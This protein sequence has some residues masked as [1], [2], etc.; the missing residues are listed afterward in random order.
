MLS[1]AVLSGATPQ[2]KAAQI[3]REQERIER[4][5]TR[6]DMPLP[7]G[8]ALSA[9][10][11][12]SAEIKKIRPEIPNTTL[13]ADAD[14]IEATL[15]QI[16]SQFNKIG[17][18]F[19][20]AVWASQKGWKIAR[21]NSPLRLTPDKPIDSGSFVDYVTSDISAKIVRWQIQNE[22]P[23]IDATVLTKDMQLIDRAQP[24]IVAAYEKLGWTATD[25]RSASL[26]AWKRARLESPLGPSETIDVQSLVESTTEMGIMVFTSE[27][28]HA[29]VFINSVKIGTTNAQ[30]N[31][32]LRF[33]V[34][35]QKVTVRFIKADFQPQNLDCVAKGQDTV[36]CKAELKHQP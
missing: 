29:D 8:I 24:N 10:S 31:E 12:T 5:P 3:K 25:A 35:G 1:L 4:V 26:V 19:D 23:E 27:P 30:K 34:D 17:L 36:I 2:K 32:P 21:L 20:D 7:S 18:T 16:V 9:F 14:I 22:N 28:D 6:I 15:P 11:Q 33:F 13:K